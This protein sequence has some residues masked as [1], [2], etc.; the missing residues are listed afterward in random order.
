MSGPGAPRQAPCPDFFLPF[1]LGRRRHGGYGVWASRFDGGRAPD[2]GA[3]FA[4]PLGS[5][6][7][8]DR[9]S[10]PAAAEQQ[11]P[12]CRP[13]A[14]P[15]GASAGRAGRAGEGG[16]GR[17]DVQRHRDLLACLV[18]VISAERRGFCRAW[19]KKRGGRWPPPR[20]RAWWSVIARSPWPSLQ[21]TGRC[22]GDAPLPDA[23]FFV[24]GGDGLAVVLGESRDAEVGQRVVEQLFQRLVRD[25]GDL[26]A[27]ADAL[28]DLERAAD[29]GD[30]IS[31]FC[32][33]S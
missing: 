26:R 7:R 22:L 25:G 12:R 27:G 33:K 32:G 8:P 21:W 5:S 3:G 18:T 13:G 10:A 2:G 1:A 4:A 11:L 30:Q 16:G 17:R 6:E 15:G 24:E 23:P 20:R 19:R 14:R 31:G 9:R 29:G 28:D